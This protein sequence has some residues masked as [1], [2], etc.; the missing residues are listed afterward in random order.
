MSQGISGNSLPFQTYEEFQYYEMR[1]E[2]KNYQILTIT[3]MAYRFFINEIKYNPSS[4][5][6]KFLNRLSKYPIAAQKKILELKKDYDEKD[7]LFKKEEKKLFSPKP[8][9]VFCMIMG[10]YILYSAARDLSDYLNLT[11]LKKI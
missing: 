3:E 5:A 7:L 9:E 4:D 1:N 6:K 10:V 2:I 11:N 8:W